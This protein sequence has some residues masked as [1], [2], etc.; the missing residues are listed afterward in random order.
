MAQPPSYEAS[1]NPGYQ[2]PL[3]QPPD[4]A[5]PPQNGAYPPQ[6]GAYPPPN[7]GM[8]YPPPTQGYQPVPADQQQ[9]Y[10]YPGKQEPGVDV[11]YQG[12]SDD[13]D[14][15]TMGIISFDDKSIRLSK[16]CS[17]FVPLQLIAYD[18]L[19]LLLLPLLKGLLDTTKMKL[20]NSFF[21]LSLIFI[22][23]FQVSSERFLA[24]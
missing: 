21:K 18:L 5:Y 12:H 15:Q 19:L 8:A 24:S 10:V 13:S 2:A 23:L 20:V 3:Y 11:E 1:Q 6:N 4:G 7:T 22:L 17:V 9:P 14:K 16:S